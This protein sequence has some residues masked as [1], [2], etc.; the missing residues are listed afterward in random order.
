[1]LMHTISFYK[2]KYKCQAREVAQR[3][4]H[5]PCKPDNLSLGSEKADAIAHAS[6]ISAHL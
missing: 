5:S 4:R 6:V 1:M 3:V 2:E